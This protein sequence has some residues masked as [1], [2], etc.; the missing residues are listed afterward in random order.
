MEENFKAVEDEIKAKLE[1]IEM[2]E[3]KLLRKE[4]AI[5]KLKM[6][7]LSDKRRNQEKIVNICCI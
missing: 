4:E 1:D 5:E 6:A 7:V 3:Q 2:Q